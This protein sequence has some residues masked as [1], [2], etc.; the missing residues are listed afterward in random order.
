MHKLSF[1][2]FSPIAQHFFS[3]PLQV[4]IA[5]INCFSHNVQLQSA[6]SSKFVRVE[7]DRVIANENSEYPRKYTTKHS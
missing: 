6:C 4:L 3:P 2:F 5:E 7:K 1:F